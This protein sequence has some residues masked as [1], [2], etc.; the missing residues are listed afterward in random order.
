MA[1]KVHVTKLDETQEEN[2]IQM[3]S[4][5]PVAP[6][7][8]QMWWNDSQQKLSLYKSGVEN[9]LNTRVLAADP[10]APEENESWINTTSMSLNYHSG[11]ITTAINFGAG[12]TAN[13]SSSTKAGYLK[14]LDDAELKLIADNDTSTA[15]PDYV[16]ESFQDEKEGVVLTNADIKASKLTLPAGQLV[17]SYE[18]SQRSSTKVNNVDGIMVATIQGLAPKLIT[19]NLD[20]THS[21]K[22]HGDVSSYFANSKNVFAFEVIEQYGHAKSIYL[23][24]SQD[25]PAVLTTNGPATYNAGA[26]E[27]D[28]LLG[29]LGLDLSLGVAAIDQY[30]SVRFAPFGMKVEAAGDGAG[31]TYS[32]LLIEEA[33]SLE[34]RR[35]LG[36]QNL[37]I[38]EKDLHGSVNR[39]VIQHSPDKTQWL[40]AAVVERAANSNVIQLWFS[41]DGLQTLNEAPFDSPC[42]KPGGGESENNANFYMA[43]VPQASFNPRLMQVFDDGRFMFSHFQYSVNGYYANQFWFGDFSGATFEARLINNRPGAHSGSS[44]IGNTVHCYDASMDYDEASDTLAFMH[45]E[46]GNNVYTLFFRINWAS[47]TS[48][49]LNWFYNGTDYGAHH[50]PLICLFEDIEGERQCFMAMTHTN[51]QCYAHK[52]SLA[53]IDATLFNV[54]ISPANQ[55]AFSLSL[56]NGNRYETSAFVHQLGTTG[57]MVGMYHDKIEKQLF[58]QY[59]DSSSNEIFLVVV[60]F[61]R[62]RAGTTT[63]V[64]YT[65]DIASDSGS[66]GYTLDDNGVSIG[67]G[68]FAYN[69]TAG[70]IETTLETIYP[71]LGN[72]TVTGDLQTS[73]NISFDDNAAHDFVITANNLL[74]GATPV[75]ETREPT[76]VVG[77]TAIHLYWDN[78]VDYFYRPEQ[79]LIPLTSSY[80][81]DWAYNEGPYSGAMGG[82][83]FQQGTRMFVDGETVYMAFD[84][85]EFSGDYD[86]SKSNLIKI[87]NYKE[88]Y[89]MQ[90]VNTPGSISPVS[91]ANP[92]L[93]L[94][95]G[96]RIAQI[97]TVPDIPTHYQTAR[98]GNFSTYYSDGKVPFRTLS[99]YCRKSY[100]GDHYIRDEQRVSIKLV[101]VSGGVPD[102]G[103]VLAT[104]FSDRKSKDFPQYD[105]YKWI[106]WSFDDLRLTPGSQACIII[107]GN[108]VPSALPYSDPSGKGTNFYGMTQY[109]ARSIASSTFFREISGAWES[110]NYELWFRAFDYYLIDNHMAQDNLSWKGPVQMNNDW[111]YMD[112]ETTLAPDGPISNKTFMLT[113]R[114]SSY[115]KWNAT[116]SGASDGVGSKTYYGTIDD[117]GGQ[118]SHPTYG[119]A[120]QVG[121]QDSLGDRYME[122]GINLGTDESRSKD[123]R[124]QEN[125]I[126]DESATQAKQYNYI[127]PSGGTISTLSTG[128]DYDGDKEGTAF[129]NFVDT[130]F[131][132]GK[133]CKFRA[134][135]LISWNYSHYAGRI[136]TNDCCIEV[137]IKPDPEDLNSSDHVIFEKYG[138]FSV[139]T[140]QGKYYCLF[141]HSVTTTGHWFQSNED[142]IDGYHRFRFGRD[143]DVGP[144]MEVS[145]DDGV[146]WIPLTLGTGAGDVD[147]YKNGLSIGY[148]N[149][150]YNFYTIGR[151]QN[152]G[153]AY[154]Y[155][156][157]GYIKYVIGTRDFAYD[158]A[159]KYEGQN[160]R[161]AVYNFGDKF[162]GQLVN[163]NSLSFDETIADAFLAYPDQ[164]TSLVETN[165]QLFKYKDVIATGRDLAV[166]VT[167]E[168]NTDE[169]PASIQGFLLNYEKK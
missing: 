10:V 132:T 119:P 126:S 20:G 97:I 125:K 150:G 153:A 63:S 104:A 17:G 60:N 138:Q 163:Q 106:N 59:E 5:N 64:D 65:F 139:R 140:Y 145:T 35:V 1:K 111:G 110:Q 12:G 149:T 94:G 76:T 75:V 84:G 156:K 105:D 113:Y 159:V 67:G 27:T 166:K 118:Y 147:L 121:V 82:R 33:H 100:S 45:N 80:F 162:I 86:Y 24:D 102:E 43:I 88:C 13:Q 109:G 137:E 2:A 152:S 61:E 38:I 54:V 164:L 66:I 73:I 167:L 21:I 131:A 141:W 14:V 169:D 42:V 124:T 95:Y 85:I 37:H 143:S 31:G 57:R 112:S 148:N 128:L 96:D 44:L 117:N 58:L 70:A 108:Y 168:K 32:E 16:I 34:E 154:W 22:F 49:F 129:G 77:Q 4:D 103:N 25:R 19:D 18:R 62:T 29:D 99:L 72:I 155:G 120:K 114:N 160:Q 30:D 107:E 146:S 6:V 40:I 98:N 3:R 158:G 81:T 115:N 136:G 51:S 26:D 161:K 39:L 151:Y 91:L 87:P 93:A 28:V 68:L 9:I 133:A 116:G 127:T 142:V 41:T 134:Q 157:I 144:F 90:V 7:E 78:D 55:P 135:G 165:D 122:F 71:Q 74:L 53:Q 11:G 50:Y 56:E 23:L 46:N 69:D 83:R 48:Q 47:L 52:V 92:A 15:Y 8:N 130:D 123:P 89:G 79:T 101:A 36:K